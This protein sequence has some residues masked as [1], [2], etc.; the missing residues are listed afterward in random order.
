MINN[1]NKKIIYLKKFI[2]IF[3]TIISKKLMGNNCS[4]LTFC[5]SDTEIEPGKE[6]NPLRTGKL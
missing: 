2:I 6:L 3:K 4:C 5:H 1:N